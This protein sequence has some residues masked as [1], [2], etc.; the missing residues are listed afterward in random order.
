MKGLNVKL[1]KF[2]KEYVLNRKTIAILPVVIRDERIISSVIEEDDEFL[3]L[4]S[5]FEIIEKSCRYFGSS[6]SGRKEGTKELIGVTHKAPICISPTDN[7]YF[8]PT[9]SYT[10]KECAW[11]SHY[12]VTSSKSLPHNTLLI[13][14]SNSKRIKIEISK[15]SFEN[16]LHR[17]AQLRSAF[18]DRKDRQNLKPFQF[19]D[20][21]E[22]F[23]HASEDEN[24]YVAE[25][26][27]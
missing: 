4:Q 8:F 7:I 25:Y 23:E 19:A 13:T 10:R 14:F 16:Q 26:D 5:P 27:E 15:G 24:V 6:F 1:E 11:V 17:T 22:L 18:E 20:K 21:D 2:L 3:V 12:H 9:L